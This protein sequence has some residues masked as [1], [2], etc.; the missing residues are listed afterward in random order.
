MNNNNSN[1]ILTAT[2]FNKTLTTATSNKD[3][4]K[5][6]KRERE[7]LQRSSLCRNIN[8]EY[9]TNR[10]ILKHIFNMYIV[11]DIKIYSLFILF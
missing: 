5:K 4:E 11:Y 3:A 10:T 9:S 6:W 8:S 2:T 7:R 1:I